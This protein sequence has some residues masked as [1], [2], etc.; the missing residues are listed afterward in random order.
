MAA[1]FGFSVGDFI[2]AV[3]LVKDVVQALRESSGSSQEFIE[4]INRLY[5]L[6]R[7]LLDI[8]N[9]QIGSEDFAQYIALHSTVALCRS[10]IDSFVEGIG[11][12]QP[13]LRLGGSN[14]HYL[15]VLRKVQWRLCKREDLLRFQAEIESYTQIIQL[16]MMR[17]QMHAEIPFW[18]ENCL[19]FHSHHTSTNTR[20]LGQ[21][22]EQVIQN[23]G[24]MQHVSRDVTEIIETSRE[25]R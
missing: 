10:S 6:E 18:I 8:N 13:H 1:T 16:L 20:C 25:M 15:T 11:K 24:D 23:G 3:Y 14:N 17:I 19:Q 12:Y 2:Q 5:C 4:I 21:L 7:A 9:L 22:S